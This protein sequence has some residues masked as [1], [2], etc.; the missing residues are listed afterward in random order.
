MKLQKTIAAL[1]V[2]AFMMACGSSVLFA[3]GNGWSMSKEECAKLQTPFY[4]GKSV[5]EVARFFPHPNGFMANFAIQELINR[6]ESVVPE[7]TELLQ[8][9]HPLVKSGALSVLKGLYACQERGKGVRQEATPKMRAVLKSV[10]PLLEDND[11]DV[12]AAVMKLAESFKAECPELHEI[13]L[14]NAAYDDQSVRNWAI[15]LAGSFL[16]DEKVKVKTAVIFLEK[17]NNLNRAVGRAQSILVKHADEA[18]HAI[19]VAGRFL[20]E[21]AIPM[22]GMFA[23][24]EGFYQFLDHHAKDPATTKVAPTVCKV[25]TRKGWANA[26]ARQLFVNMGP[27]AV[28]IIKAHI[29]SEKEYL[30]TAPDSDFRSI[31]MPHATRESLATRIA[32]LEHVAECVAAD[33]EF[34]MK[35]MDVEESILDAPAPEFDPN[36]VEDVE[37]LTELP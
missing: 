14:K 10:M 36:A 20:E 16:E 34:T 30:K 13:I 28:P 32:E 27:T 25:Y 15:S 19:P 2:A 21:E 33:K 22:Q 8:D 29:T 24:I 26:A 1:L 9:S 37:E 4:K 5:K 31:K 17:K 3:G 23:S 11:K 12:S 6:G 7:V 18:I 35:F